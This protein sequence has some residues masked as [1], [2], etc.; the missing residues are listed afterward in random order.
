MIAHIRAQDGLTQA[1][2]ARCEAVGCLC[3]RAAQPLGLDKTAQLIGL[4]HDMGK[5]TQAFRA[6]LLACSEDVPSPHNHAPTGAI[7]AYI[8]MPIKAAGSLA[9]FEKMLLILSP[10]YRTRSFSFRARRSH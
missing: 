10:C 7:F 8:M 1:L 3:S 4:L 9:M 2:G 6:Y 5:A